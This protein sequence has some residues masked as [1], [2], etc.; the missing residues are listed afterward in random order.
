MYI[1]C[2]RNGNRYFGKL[3]DHL[4]PIKKMLCLIFCN[5]TKSFFFCQPTF[6][7]N[8]GINLELSRLERA[9]ALLL[10]AHLQPSQEIR[11]LEISYLYVRI[12][13]YRGSGVFRAGGGGG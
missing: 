5:S 7:K 12:M 11:G 10:A 3:I 9:S 6:Y 4:S 2:L 8:P 1:Y 13:W